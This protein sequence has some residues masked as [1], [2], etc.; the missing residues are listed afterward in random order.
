MYKILKKKLLNKE[1]CEMWVEAPR[2]AKKQSPGQFIIFRADEKGERVPLTIAGS[3][4]K[5]GAVRIIFQMIGAS[6]MKLG[7]LN[8]GDYI[9]D[10]AGP[11]GRAS[12]LESYRG[13]KVA[14][15]GG[16]LGAAIAFPQAVGLTKIGADV[17]FIL[18]FRNK[19]LIILEDEMRESCGNL[20]ITTDDGSNGIKGFTSDVLEERILAGIKYDLVIAVGPMMMMKVTC[21]L[22]E[23]Y[24]IP[25]IVSMNTIMVDGTGMCGGCRLTVDGKTKFACV[26]GPDFD[27]H[28]VDFIE[29]IRRSRTYFEEEKSAKERHICNLTGEVR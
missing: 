27:G 24:D 9:R 25:T 19:D 5:T 16:G 17:D 26:D 4:L 22:T 2:I 21:D 20:F 29:A 13:K 8:E 7:A 12:D 18:G 15:C 11:L 28:K 23:K 3:D 14:V 1:T 6:T 10:F